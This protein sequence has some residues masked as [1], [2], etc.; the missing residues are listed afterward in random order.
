MAQ[1]CTSMPLARGW[2]HLRCSPRVISNSMACPS[3]KLAT[4]SA[5]CLSQGHI[6]QRTLLCLPGAVVSASWSPPPR[7][8]PAAA[9]AAAAPCQCDQFFLA[10]G[11]MQQRRQCPV[12]CA[13]LSTRQ[14]GVVQKTKQHNSSM[15]MGR[16]M[17]L[18]RVLLVEG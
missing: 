13:V 7:P 11:G 15:G 4:T 17:T 2:L 3:G 16:T 10:E 12:R 5:R 18:A 14:L 9:A 1:Q 6:Q 8:A